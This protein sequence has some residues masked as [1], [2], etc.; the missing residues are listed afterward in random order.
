MAAA[1][2]DRRRSALRAVPLTLAL[3]MLAVVVLA[4]LLP[5][6]GVVSAT[7]NCTYGKCPATTPFPFWAVSAAVVVVVLALILAL[8]LLRRRRA[9]P[10]AG[11]AASSGAGATGPE[12]PPEGQM[13]E[14]EPAEDS[15]GT[16][17]PT[18][19]PEEQYDAPPSPDEDAAG[20][21]P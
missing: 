8:L 12:T 16:E 21:A 3:A 10:P 18:S 11:P 5:N 2:S 4:G 20:P 17:E 6:T 15:G 13:Y 7:S 1:P 9:R 14:S 19:P